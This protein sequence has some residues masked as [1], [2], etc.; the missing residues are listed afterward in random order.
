MNDVDTIDETMTK[1]F[2][3][4]ANV[5]RKSISSAFR[6]LCKFIFA[7]E[8]QP[9]DKQTSINICSLCF[10]RP[11][12]ADGSYVWWM[13]K[14]H[15][16]APIDAWNLVRHRRDASCIVNEDEGNLEKRCI[17]WGPH[18][19]E[20]EVAVFGDGLDLIEDKMWLVC[21]IIL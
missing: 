9:R 2:D 17:G 18:D 13:V 21:T 1:M 8:G 6:T 4:G 12:L 15:G 20:K 3:F 10:R 19:W 7:T 5:H 11:S 16:W 14:H